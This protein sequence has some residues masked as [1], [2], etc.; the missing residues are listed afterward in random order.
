MISNKQRLVA[1]ITGMLLFTSALVWTKATPA[2]QAN[3][4]APNQVANTNTAGPGVTIGTHRIYKGIEYV[5]NTVPVSENLYTKSVEIVDENRQVCA[6]ISTTAGEPG[7]Q[8]FKN[9]NETATLT[10]DALSMYGPPVNNRAPML[11]QLGHIYED[12]PELT[13]YDHKGN[14]RVSVEL[15]HQV[16][17]ISLKDADGNIRTLLAA[18]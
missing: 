4:L 5:A 9:G 8:F 2:Q 6:R 12:N 16:P 13:I 7:I 10:G 11:I 1:E 14:G 3:Q 15:D 18:K 17:S